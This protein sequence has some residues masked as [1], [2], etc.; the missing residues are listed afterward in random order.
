MKKRKCCIL[1]IFFSS[2]ITAIAPADESPGDEKIEDTK[3]R[4][5]EDVEAEEGHHHSRHPKMPEDADYGSAIGG[6]FEAIFSILEVWG[7]Y[8]LGVR[9]AA[10]PYA[11]TLYHYNTSEMD[12]PEQ[13]K[14]LSLQLSSEANWH[15]GNT[16]GQNNKLSFRFSA[17]NFNLFNQNIFAEHQWLYA[18]SADGGLSFLAP[19]FALDLFLGA[20]HL[21]FLSQVFLSFGAQVLLFFRPHLYFEVYNLNSINGGLEFY[22]LSGCLSYA[23]GRWGI[24]AGFNYSSYNGYGYFGPL[25]RLSL[26]F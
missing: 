25:I 18:V 19:N 1:L 9:Y 26:W 7:E 6:I 23:L 12:F 17:F 4:V 10:Y 13:D 8:S 15:V 2:V 21:D 14:I 11:T 16:Y 5:E 20:I 24:G 3:E 22:Y